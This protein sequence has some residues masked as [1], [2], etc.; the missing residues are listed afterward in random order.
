MNRLE[1]GGLT[2]TAAVGI[3]ANL[4][5]ESNLDPAIK[6]L[7][8]GPGR[9]LAQWEKGGRYDTDPIN[10]VKF[11]KKKGTDWSDLDTQIDFI[12]HEMERHPEYK[13]VKDMLNKA[14]NVEDATLIFLKKYEKAGTPHTDKR[15]KF[16]KDLETQLM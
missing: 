4:K 12:L 13:R 8:G 2:P 16:A 10:L 7:S 9:G 6:Q 14:G 1:G 3:V 5:A 11:A 15:L